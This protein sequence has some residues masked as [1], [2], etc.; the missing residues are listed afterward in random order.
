[1]ANTSGGYLPPDRLHVAVLTGGQDWHYAYGLSESLVAQNVGIDVIGT[2]EVARP[3]LIQLPGVRFFNLRG[4]QHSNASFAWKSWRV[5]VYYLKLLRYA[6]SAEPRLFHILWNNK[7]AW[8]DRTLLMLYYRLL[9]KR[10]ALTAHNINQAKRDAC[11]SPLNRVTLR[12]QYH[13]SDQVFVHT[14]DMKRELVKDFGV[15]ETAITVIPYGINNAVPSKGISGAEARREM[16]IESHERV[17]LFFGAIAPYKGLHLL[18]RAF[19]TLVAGD[20]RYRLVIAGKPK[21]G[22]EAYLRSV[23]DKLQA[24]SPADRVTLRIEHIPDTSIELYFGAA[25]A[26]V[27]PYTHIFQSGVLFLAFRFGLPVIASDVGCFRDDVVDCKTGFLCRPSD[28]ADL[29]RAIERY[30]SSDLYRELDLRRPQIRDLVYQK[31]SWKVVGEMTRKIYQQI[32]QG[33]AI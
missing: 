24:T 30:F 14:E 32:Q 27:L 19:A 12:M 17:L 1:L 31:H 5:L 21:G 16:G 29:T 10:V 28:T 22:C 13:L 7:F 33:R 15:S 4:G 2:D 3:E 20:A 18:A 6:V 26:L 8:F 23:L 25:D 11:D 9:G